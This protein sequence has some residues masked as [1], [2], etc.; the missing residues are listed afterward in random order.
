MS[1]TPT[2]PQSLGLTGIWATL[3]NLTAVVVVVGLFVYQEVNFWTTYELERAQRREDNAK[4]WQ[5]V[6]DLSES[7]DRMSD[8]LRALRGRLKGTSG[9]SK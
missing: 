4:Q 8:E 6:R 2:H 1:S 3:T 5:R 7:V 9:T